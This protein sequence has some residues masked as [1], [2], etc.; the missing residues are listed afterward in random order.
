[1][2]ISASFQNIGHRLENKKPFIHTRDEEFSFDYA[3]DRSPRYHPNSSFSLVATWSDRLLVLRPNDYMTGRLTNA[4][5]RDNGLTRHQLLGFTGE[6]S[7]A[8]GRRVR[9]FLSLSGM[10]RSRWALVKGFHL[11]LPS[12]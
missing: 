2:F 4:L 10:M 9:S 7:L 5:S 8:S 3:Q 11:T 12:R 6:V 1:M